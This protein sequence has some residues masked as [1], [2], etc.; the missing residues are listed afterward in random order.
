MHETIGF[1]DKATAMRYGCALNKIQGALFSFHK[2]AHQRSCVPLFGP[3]LEEGWAW[4]EWEARRETRKRQGS[5]CD[6]EKSGGRNEKELEIGSQC[7]EK[8]MVCKCRG[9]E[10]L[11]SWGDRGDSGGEGWKCGCGVS[12]WSV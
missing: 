4:L 7:G 3:G 6:Q 1:P 5:G 9:R 11:G 2:V 12:E 10:V 8:R